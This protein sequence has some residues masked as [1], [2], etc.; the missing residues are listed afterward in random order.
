MVGPET[1]GYGTVGL[2]RFGSVRYGQGDN[3]ERTTV[4]ALISNFFLPFQFQI[5]AQIIE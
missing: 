2:V 4:K 5:L 3:F 1:V